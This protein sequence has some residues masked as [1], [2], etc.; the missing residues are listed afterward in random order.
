MMDAL[1]RYITVYTVK[2][3]DKS[4]VNPL[5]KRN[6]TWAERQC[7]DCKIMPIISDGCREI[8]DDDMMAWYQANVIDHF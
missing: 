8:V 1:S 6:I 2:T 5:P 3:N 7:T 4:K